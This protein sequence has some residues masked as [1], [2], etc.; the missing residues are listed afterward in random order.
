M[1]STS[2]RDILKIKMKHSLLINYNI[3]YFI[4]AEY[5]WPWLLRKG[6]NVRYKFNK[7]LSSSRVVD[8]LEIIYM[9]IL[10]LHI[11]M[12]LIIMFVTTTCLSVHVF[13]NTFSKFNCN[14]P[15]VTLGNRFML[16]INLR[17]LICPFYQYI[18]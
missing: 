17:Y 8:N 4:I 13:F 2:K 3:D 9:S 5:R 12:P 18:S 7:R 6:V 16:L 14:F 15:S 11:A 10:K 1:F